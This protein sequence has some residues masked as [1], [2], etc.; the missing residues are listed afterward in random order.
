[1]KTAILFLVLFTGQ[2]LLA[3]A[4]APQA[5]NFRF[6]AAK[7][8]TFSITQSATSKEEAYKLAARECFKKMTANRYPGEER[9]LEIIDICA[10]PKM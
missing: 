8:K 5:Y 7:N 3:A 2:M 4:S 9:G 10:N 6:T 1:M